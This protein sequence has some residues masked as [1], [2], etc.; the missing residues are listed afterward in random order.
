MSF[1]HHLKPDLK[2]SFYL[3]FKIRVNTEMVVHSVVN[4]SEKRTVFRF[5]L[6]FPQNVEGVLVVGEGATTPSEH[7]QCSLEKVI[8]PTNAHNGPCDKLVTSPRMDLLSPFVS[9]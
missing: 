9:L 6:H 2:P 4:W 1:K 7:C 5:E 3:R 8:N